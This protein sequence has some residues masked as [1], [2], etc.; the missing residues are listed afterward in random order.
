MKGGNGGGGDDG[1]ESYEVAMATKAMLITK[2]LRR[3]ASAA[4]PKFMRLLRSLFLRPAIPSASREAL[5]PERAY[6][7]TYASVSVEVKFGPKGF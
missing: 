4:S 2:K 7:R 5:V 6:L 1:S 3:S